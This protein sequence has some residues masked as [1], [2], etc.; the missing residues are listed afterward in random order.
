M[1][2]KN[3][4][5]LCQLKSSWKQILLCCCII[6]YLS[7]LY[8]LKDQLL[9]GNLILTNK[10]RAFSSEQNFTCIWSVVENRE[11]CKPVC[12]HGYFGLYGMEKCH[13]LLTC[14]DIAQLKLGGKIGNWGYVKEA[15]IKLFTYNTQ[16]LI[17]F[18][19]LSS[20]WIKE[21]AIPIDWNHF[22][23]FYSMHYTINIIF[24]FTF[25]LTG[26]RNFVFT[27]RKIK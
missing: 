13:S 18:I 1:F 11:M 6:V 12:N 25:D 22:S 3:L 5:Y 4:Q 8:I 19:L 24:V 20:K 23:R 17:H 16:C 27:E 21:H 26:S 9:P 10:P 14:E 2:P 15:R 7:F